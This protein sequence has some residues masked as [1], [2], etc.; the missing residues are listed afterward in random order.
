MPA[1]SSVAPVAVARLI[2]AAWFA[3]IAAWCVVAAGASAPRR[4]WVGSRSARPV[5]TAYRN[6]CPRCCLVRCAV[7]CLPHTSRHRKTLSDSIGMIL[8]S[9]DCHVGFDQASERL[10]GFFIVARESISVVFEPFLRDEGRTRPPWRPF[11]Q[12][13]G[14]WID[15]IRD[16]AAEASMPL[17]RVQGIARRSAMPW[18]QHSGYGAAMR[19]ISSRD[20]KRCRR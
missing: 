14:G 18:D 1:S 5:A 17:P 11:D 2:D 6:T 12:P 10:L 4:S 20:L 3:L 9:G 7:S 13:L 19:P 15:T 16:Q 8:E